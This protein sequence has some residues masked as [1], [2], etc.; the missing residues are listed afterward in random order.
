MLGLSFV[1]DLA[2]RRRKVNLQGLNR[3]D[4]ASTKDL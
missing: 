2:E 4:V 1:C 3:D